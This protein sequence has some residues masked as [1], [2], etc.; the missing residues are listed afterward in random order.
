[1]KKLCFWLERISISVI[2]TKIKLKKEEKKKPQHLMIE[3][4]IHTT[5]SKDCFNEKD[6]QFMQRK[7]IRVR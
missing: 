6:Y 7:E 2:S 3:N 4:K 5:H 1:M